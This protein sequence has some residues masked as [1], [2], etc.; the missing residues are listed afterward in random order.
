MDRARR[1]AQTHGHALGAMNPGA[2]EGDYI[3]ICA[4][5]GALAIVSIRPEFAGIR[6]TACS[7]DCRTRQ[8]I[9]LLRHDP[10][11]AEQHRAS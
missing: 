9:R 1:L 10:S 7:R 3:G 11:R 5:C 6:G 8:A 4:R 2:R